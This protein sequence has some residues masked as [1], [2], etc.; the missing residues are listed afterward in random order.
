M[1][2]KPELASERPGGATRR[3]RFSLGLAV[4][5]LG[6]RSGGGVWRGL[7][8]PVLS[9]LLGGS[10]LDRLFNWSHLAISFSPSLAPV[11]NL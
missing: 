5:G 8:Y 9:A 3:D 10:K 7:I 11:D 6:L 1:A 4:S 2:A